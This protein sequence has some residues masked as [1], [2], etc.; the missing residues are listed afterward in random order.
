M[1]WVHPYPSTPTGSWAGFSQSLRQAADFGHC[2]VEYHVSFPKQPLSSTLGKF[3]PA[4]QLAWAQG[5][6]LLAHIRVIVNTGVAFGVGG[7]ICR[8]IGGIVGRDRVI[9]VFL[10]VFTVWLWWPRV[11]YGLPY[12]YE[13]DEAHHFNR[14]VE[15]VKSGELDPHYFHK[16]S[17]HFY[18]RIPAIALS[19]LNE[20]R[21]GRAKKV[22]DIVTRDPAGVGGYAFSTSHPG[23]VKTARLVSVACGVV[24]VLS[25]YAILLCLTGKVWWGVF[26]ALLTLGSKLLYQYGAEVGVDIVTAACVLACCVVAV[27]GEGERC[28]VS[29]WCGLQFISGARH[30]CEVQ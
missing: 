4:T 21:K 12:F 2:D 13:E 15:M 25:V 8:A 29:C 6:P 10:A 5:I 18:L 11:E 23:I 27:W 26:G 9:V 19:F 22:E 30:W 16:P 3:R 28:S 20:V 1:R 14:T 17:L 7:G 24:V